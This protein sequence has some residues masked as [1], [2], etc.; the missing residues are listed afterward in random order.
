MVKKEI[1]QSAVRSYNNGFTVCVSACG[2]QDT[3]SKE[4]SF[5]EAEEST[6]ESK[7]A[8]TEA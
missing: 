5:E 6:E 1:T 2:A 3:A 8:G 4:T 7:D